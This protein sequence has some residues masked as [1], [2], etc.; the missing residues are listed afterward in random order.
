MF[1]FVI[2]NFKDRS[3]RFENCVL[4]CNSSENILEVYIQ[5]SYFQYKATDIISLIITK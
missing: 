1:S 3:L 4:V 2:I 5:S